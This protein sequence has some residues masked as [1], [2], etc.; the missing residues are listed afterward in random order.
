[1]KSIFIL[2]I[3]CSVLFSGC[4]LLNKIAPSQV[5]EVG[6]TL[7]GT[8]ELSPIAKTVTDATGPYGQAVAAIFLLAWNFAER[9]KSK[10]SGDGLKSTL[11]GLKSAAEDPA[12]KLAFE[13]IKLYLKNAH[14]SAGVR[15]DIDALLAKI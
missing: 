11:A 15:K 13:Q 2:F 14:D 12:T 7:P 8:H 4:A 1:M 6:Q 10:K 9:A 5:D 3:V